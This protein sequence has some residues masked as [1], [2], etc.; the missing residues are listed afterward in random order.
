MLCVLVCIKFSSNLRVKYLDLESPV[1]TN[2][3]MVKIRYSL[4]VFLGLVTFKTGME[5]SLCVLW[6]DCSFC[7][8]CEY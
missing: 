1:E 3:G 8:W 5:T 7:V 6:M 4:S 2:T